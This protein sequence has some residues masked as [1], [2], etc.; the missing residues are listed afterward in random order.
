[1]VPPSSSADLPNSFFFPS[2]CFFSYSRS[3]FI[4][5]C[6]FFCICVFPEVRLSPG[7]SYSLPDCF[8]IY[9][10]ELLRQLFSIRSVSF[11]S[12]SLDLPC[13]LLS[14]D[15]QLCASVPRKRRKIKTYLLDLL[16]SYVA[17]WTPLTT[18]LHILKWLHK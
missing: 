6:V 17:L 9:V 10:V 8:T 16:F 14:P 15:P 18:T 5:L 2:R 3:L 12:L 13:A 4:F 1:M 7:S 11:M